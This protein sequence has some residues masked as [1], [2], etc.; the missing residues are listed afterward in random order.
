MLLYPVNF[1]ITD[2]LCL[3]VGGGGVALRKTKSLLAG[4][5]KVRVISLEVHDEL[6]KL[7]QNKQIELFERG[8]AEGDL[9]G[10]F[11]VF[12]ATNNPAVQ[13]LIAAEAAR[14]SVLLNSATDPRIS[15]F[16]VPAHF[17]RG[18]MLVTVSTGGSSPAFAKK[19]RQRLEMELSPEYELVV[20]LLSL[21]R[22]EVVSL[23]GDSVANGKIFNKL[24]QQGI[25]ELILEANWFDLQMML[26]RELPESADG[27]GLLKIFLEKYDRSN[28]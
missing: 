21:I 22:E 13:T 6:R 25:V 16:H 27:V 9:K 17:R 10:V 23:G 24:L 18:K 28:S 3:V 4:M 12:A 8:F 26:L 15:D 19:I 20:E 1:N 7:A 11:L 2:K 14:C 5:A